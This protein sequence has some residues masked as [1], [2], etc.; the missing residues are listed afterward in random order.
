MKWAVEVGSG[1]I[2]FIPDFIKFG[3]GI[4]MLMADGDTQTHGQHGDL[5]SL[6]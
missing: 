6:L 4:K 2:I 5:I 1:A 3:S